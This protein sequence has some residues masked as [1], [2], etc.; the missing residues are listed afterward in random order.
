MVMEMVVG[1]SN[2]KTTS[3]SSSSQFR[4]NDRT[5]LHNLEANIKLGI[6]SITLSANIYNRTK[7]KYY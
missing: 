3:K 4:L 6:I 2:P 5:C 1:V 7:L